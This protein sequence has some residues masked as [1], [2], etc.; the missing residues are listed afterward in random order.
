MAEDCETAHARRELTSVH[1]KCV[2]TRACGRA[3]VAK[4]CYVIDENVV[5]GACVRMCCVC[6]V[7]VCDVARVRTETNAD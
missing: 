2:R 5:R 1:V 3:C 6:L 7:G 4:C